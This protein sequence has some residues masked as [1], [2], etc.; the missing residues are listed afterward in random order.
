LKAGTDLLQVRAGNGQQSRERHGLA[1]EG[2]CREI[3]WDFRRIGRRNE[4][5]GHASRSKMLGKREGQTV[6]QLD[7]EE[8]EVEPFGREGHRFAGIAGDEG[9]AVEL[10][11]NEGSQVVCYQ[12]I[13]LDNEYMLAHGE[14]ETPRTGN[15]CG[16]NHK[17][18]Y[19]TFFCLLRIMSQMQ[20]AFTI[21]APIRPSARQ[22]LRSA[23]TAL[24]AE[25]DGRFSGPFE[26]DKNAYAAFLTALARAVLPLERALEQGE[27]ERLIPDWRSRR[28]SGALERDLDILGI[29]VPVP[30]AVGVTRDEARV[31]G[32]VYVLEGSRLGGSLLVKRARA[33]ADPVVRAATNFLAHGA[34]ADLWRG[35]LR[36]LEDSKAVAAAPERTMLGAREAFDLFRVDTA[37]A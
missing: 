14:V 37:H 28:R 9:H 1:Q 19:R 29:P 21:A 27:V 17:S 18:V 32:R 6:R 26:T 23:T 16:E 34:G 22:M 31:F 4:D 24:H 33:N 7:V 8:A 3:G 25:V 12:F 36:R 11:A 2:G 20:R 30:I 5:E 13:V 35:F 10:V 15:G